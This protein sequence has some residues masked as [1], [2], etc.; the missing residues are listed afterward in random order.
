MQ[1]LFKTAIKGHQKTK[2][3][4]R[5]IF[6]ILLFLGLMPTLFAQRKVADTIQV[7]GI[8]EMC[9]ERIEKALDIKGI[10]VAEWDIETKLLYVVYRPKKISKEEIGALLAAIGHDNEI[11]LASDASYESIHSCCRYRDAVVRDEHQTK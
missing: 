10:W 3:M 9:K 7:E 8:C 11:A 5:N 6:L 2:I 4:K 1:I